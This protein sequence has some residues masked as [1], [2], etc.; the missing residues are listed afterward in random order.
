MFISKKVKE[1]NDKPWKKLTGRHNKSSDNHGFFKHDTRK[2]TE[3]L[4]LILQ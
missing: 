3:I 1:G 4:N 2:K